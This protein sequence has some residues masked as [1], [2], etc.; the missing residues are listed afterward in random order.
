MYFIFIQIMINFLHVYVL[1]QRMSRIGHYA[2][3]IKNGKIL[4]SLGIESWS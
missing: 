1:A 3:Q 4:L 2:E